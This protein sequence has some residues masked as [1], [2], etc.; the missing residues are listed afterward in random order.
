ML[1]EQRVSLIQDINEVISSGRTVM[2]L[3]WMHKNHNDFT[4]NIPAKKVIFQKHAPGTIGDGCGLVLCTRYISH[5]TM[6]RVSKT[7]RTVRHVLGIREIQEILE[8]GKKVICEPTPVAINATSKGDPPAPDNKPTI[9][10]DDDVLDFITTPRSCIMS[11]LECF[12]RKFVEQSKISSKT[13]YLSKNILGTIRT[14]CEVGDTVAQLTRDGWVIGE[15]SEG[16]KKIG[17]YKPGE[18]MIQFLSSEKAEP[19]DPYQLAL[20]LVSQKADLQKQLM[21]VQMKLQKIEVAE[22]LLEQLDELKNMM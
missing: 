6:E 16:K 15:K 20:H 9:D 1:N 13:G 14:E 4:R 21:E 10:I 7:K 19:T 12:A 18:K 17:W 2:V 22:K 3:G 11:N 5:S 8:A